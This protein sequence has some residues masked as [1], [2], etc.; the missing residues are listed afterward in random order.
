MFSTTIYYSYFDWEQEIYMPGIVITIIIFYL[1][2][3]KIQIN[4][5]T[6]NKSHSLRL[7]LF[8][9]PCKSQFKAQLSIYFKNFI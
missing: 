1:T 2:S 7:G 3:V 6:N 4:D 8:I 9:Q 5:K